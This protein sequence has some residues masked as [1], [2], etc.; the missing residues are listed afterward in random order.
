ME[1]HERFLQDILPHFSTPF[2]IAIPIL[3]YRTP[4]V[5]DK[6]GALPAILKK[7]GYVRALIVTDS[8]LHALGM[9]D[10]L[11]KALTD[12]GVDY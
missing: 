10:P 6:V 2:K 9:I 11:K 5:T 12:E 3:P 8:T 4:K 1:G 7:E